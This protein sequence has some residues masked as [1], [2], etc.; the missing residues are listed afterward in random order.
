MESENDVVLTGIG[1]RL[2]ECNN[3]DEFMEALIN[4]VDLITETNKRFPPG[5]YYK[6]RSFQE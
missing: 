6:L 1:G 2:P 4:G 3:V 5:K